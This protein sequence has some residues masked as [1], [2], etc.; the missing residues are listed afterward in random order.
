MRA[1]CRTERERKRR[2]GNV[3]Q[4]KLREEIDK[5]GKEA[6]DDGSGRGEEGGVGKSEKE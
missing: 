2:K 6:I 1:T 5:E 3:L 4:K